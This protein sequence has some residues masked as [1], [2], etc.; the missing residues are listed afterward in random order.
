MM[1]CLYLTPKR[2]DMVECY[3]VMEGLVNLRP[4]VVQQLLESCT[5]VK[6]KRLFLYMAEKAGHQWLQFVDQTNIHLGA[7]D[8]SLVDNGVYVA[9]HHISI[10]RELA[11]L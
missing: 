9:K 10:P 6:A 11:Y 2:L 1:E 8:R 7:G 5:S 3:Q 4:K